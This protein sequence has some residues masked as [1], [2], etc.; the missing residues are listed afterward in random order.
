M[1]LGVIDLFL[2]DID[3]VFLAGKEQPRLVSG[4]RILPALRERDIPFRLVTNTSTHSAAH[5]A[6]SLGAHGVDVRAAEI[7][8]ALDATVRAASERHQGGRCVVVG[9]PGLSEAATAAGLKVVEVPPAALVLV[10]LCR[11]VDY[12]LLNR[13]ARCL[14][15][16]AA[17]FGCH[18]NRLWLDDDGE[19]LSCGAWLAALEQATGA[20]A[21]IFGKPAT[22][23]FDDARRPFGTPAERCLMVGDDLE[24]DV[25]G[26]QQAGMRGALALT[27]KTSRAAATGQPVVPDLWLDEVDDL[28]ELLTR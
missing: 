3:G 28:V 5:L 4:R 21:E 16:G 22:S 9:E 13:A 14:L 18:R 1:D 2:F 12:D 23:F 17:L 11:V 7:H 25:G 20:R 10:G 15:D 26:A 6:D 27:G 8:S 19:A 24:S